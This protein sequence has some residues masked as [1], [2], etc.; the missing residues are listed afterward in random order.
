L[1]A[2]RASRAFDPPTSSSLAEEKRLR[3]L[4]A[5]CSLRSLGLALVSRLSTARAIAD[6]RSWP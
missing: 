3:F 2:A 6:V 1:R 4:R 5:H